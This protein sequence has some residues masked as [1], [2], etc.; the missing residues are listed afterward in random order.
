MIGIDGSGF[1]ELP[2]SFAGATTYS[3]S[4]TRDGTALLAKMDTVKDVSSIQRVPIDG[5]KPTTIATNL[6]ELLSFDISPDQRRI[7]YSINRPTTD[8]WML[9]LRGALK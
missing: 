1:R 6:G 8:V 2:G 4:W 5:G 9:D 7:A 3:V